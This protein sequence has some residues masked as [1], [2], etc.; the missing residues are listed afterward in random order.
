[1]L[2]GIIWHYSHFADKE[3]DD[4]KG[5]KGEKEAQKHIERSSQGHLYNVRVPLQD[6]NVDLLV[7]KI[8]K[9]A[10]KCIKT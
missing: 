6:K 2:V 4:Q 1:M 10:I 5:L 8:S 3:T 9:S 7:H